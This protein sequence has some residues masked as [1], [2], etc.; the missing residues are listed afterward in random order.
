MSRDLK[1]VIREQKYELERLLAEK[2]LDRVVM[3]KVDA[4]SHLAQAVVGMRRSGKSVVCR[5]AMKNFGAAFG[6]VDFD[7]EVLAKID[8]SDTVTRTV[9]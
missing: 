5:T 3:G 4:A 2:T 8:A 9:P 6:Y 1:K 7:D